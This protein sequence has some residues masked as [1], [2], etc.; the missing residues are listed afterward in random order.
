MSLEVVRKNRR[1]SF[2]RRTAWAT[3]L[4]IGVAGLLLTTGDPAQSDDRDLLRFSTAKPFVFVLLDTSASMNLKVGPGDLYTEGFGDDPDSRIY[5]AKEALFTVFEGVEGVTFGFATLNQDRA[6]V[7]QKHWLY[8]SV[9]PPPASWP[10]AWPLE[11]PDGLTAFDAQGSPINDVEGDA[12]VFGPHFNFAPVGEA[13][14]CATPLDFTVPLDRAKINSFAKLG[15][16]GK[17]TT[18]LWIMRPGSGSGS[19]ATY[20]LRVSRAVDS[21]ALDQ[22]DLVVDFVL[23]EVNDCLGPTFGG[24]HVMQLTMKLDPLMN[25]FVMVDGVPQTGLF[26]EPAPGLWNWR[27]ALTDASCANVDPFTG[28]GWEGNY[29]SGGGQSGDPGFDAQITNVDEIC[30]GGS[31]VEIK[32]MQPTVVSPVSS[33]LDHG[34]LLPW[35][36]TTDNH[37]EFLQRLAPNYPQSLPNFGVADHLSDTPDPVVGVHPPRILTRKPIVA[38]GETPLDNAMFDF[39][40][41]YQGNTGPGGGCSDTFLHDTGWYR[42]V[43]CDNDPEFGCRRN[44][45]IIISDGFNTC[46]PIREGDDQSRA[47]FNESNVKTWA[48]N[49]GD[50]NNCADPTNILNIVTGLGSGQCLN[51]ATKDQLLD[52]LQGVLGNIRTEARA[53]A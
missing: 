26:P 14:T 6:R 24:N 30:A 16:D 32:H 27:D 45:F 5:A 37:L 15:A 22:D 21:P 20:R 9:D 50:P 8:F 51:I 47:L 48:L 28:A 36:W 18:T 44:F 2:L 43:A 33:A 17:Q 46:D 41:W 7:I 3:A 29:D 25:D 35:D 39:R 38:M 13:A 34:D 49:V 12:Q 11:D 1:K 23:D 31:C 40:C 19:G 10:I 52:T 4:V 53:F 42:E